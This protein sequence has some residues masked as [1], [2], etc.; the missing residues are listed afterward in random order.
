MIKT[1]KNF[2]KKVNIPQLLKW[3]GNK[4]KFGLEL[5][6]YMPQEFNTYYEPFLGSGALLGIVSNLNL[7]TPHGPKFKRSVAGDT[8]KYVVDIFNYVK[9]KPDL[10]INHY[11]TCIEGY[12][13][14]KQ[15]NYE[16][17]KTRFNTTRD[18]LD[19]AVL[20]RTCYGGIIRF[21]KSDGYMSTLVG[22]HNPISP[23]S[24]A[25]R[26]MIWNGLTQDTTFMCADFSETMSLASEGDLIYCDPPYTHSQSI[27]YGAQD[28]CI[29]RLWESIYAAKQRGAKV[30]LS[31]NGT[32]ESGGKD[33]GVIP[34]EGLFERAT[35]INCGVSMIDRLQ[36]AGDVMSGDIVHDKLLL[37]W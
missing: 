31:I 18:S 22:P 7:H 20:T 29:D 23:K 8:L 15:A 24:F 9:S 32:R 25:E 10:L 17:I 21:R 5:T 14:N 26:V 35:L 2:Q 19:F 16:A 4:H 11:A 34:P 3:I 36:N 37:T 33:I 1:E 13:D 30:M 6:T 12:I 27:L 28:F